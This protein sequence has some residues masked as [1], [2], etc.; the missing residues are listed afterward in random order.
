MDNQE[1]YYF[2]KAFEIFKKTY[3]IL[4][5]LKISFLS[6]CLAGVALHSTVEVEFGN[7]KINF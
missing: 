5:T 1:C 6:F 4:V 7:A 2:L 3:H